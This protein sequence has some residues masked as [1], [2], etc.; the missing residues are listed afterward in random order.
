MTSS[1]TP[2]ITE[3]EAMFN[4]V[5]VPTNLKIDNAAVEAARQV[6][7]PNSKLELLSQL[8]TLRANGKLT[9]HQRSELVRL[10]KERDSVQNKAAI[11]PN[12]VISR[13]L[14]LLKNA[15]EASIITAR[16]EHETAQAERM[17]LESVNDIRRFANFAKQVAA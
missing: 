5:V 7:L 12:E 15:A 8:N 6:L 10:E 13:A 9:E 1:E 2:T 17:S 11:A 14:N 4:K 16:R 3:L